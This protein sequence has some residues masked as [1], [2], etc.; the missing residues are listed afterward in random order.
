M[1][2][3][4][5]SGVVNMAWDGVGLKIYSQHAVGCKVFAFF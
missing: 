5:V 4:Q 3:P 2:V 1:Q